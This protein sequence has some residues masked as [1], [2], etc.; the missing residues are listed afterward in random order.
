[1]CS[2][3][4]LFDGVL[5]TFTSFEL[6][7]GDR[8]DLDLLV[9]RLWVYTHAW[10]AGLGHEGAEAGDR[11]FA[12]CFEGVGND[13]DEGGDHVLGLFFANPCLFGDLVDEL[14]FVN[15]VHRKSEG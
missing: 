4:G 10:S 15:G 14:G 5:E 9:W 3:A 11:D 2:E 8:W 7:N 13:V 6:W 12:T 1:M